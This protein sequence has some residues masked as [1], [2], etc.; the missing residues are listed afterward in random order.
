MQEEALNVYTVFSGG[1]DFFLLGAWNDIISLATSIQK[2]FE[3]F[4]NKKLTLSAGI[5]LVKPTHPVSYMAQ[6]SEQALEA[7]KEHEDKNALTLFSK[8][9][10]WQ[11]YEETK[12]HFLKLLPK[13]TNSAFLYRILDFCHMQENLHNNIKNA[14]WRSKLNYSY[15]RNLN[16]TKN[17]EFLAFLE[18]NIEKQPHVVQ[19]LTCEHLY[20]ERN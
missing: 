3:H 2:K 13:E 16:V 11:S 17:L 6:A 19:M 12:K 9:C 1:D 10:T 14:L 15:Q 8:T 7:S 18:K 5:L 20:Q 4:L